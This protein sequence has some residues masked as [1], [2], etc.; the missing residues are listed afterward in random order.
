V[1]DRLLAE[2]RLAISSI[3][4]TSA[5][6]MNGALLAEGL[7][8]GAAGARAALARFWRGVG[9]RGRVGPFQPTLYDRLRDDGNIDTAPGWLA[10]EAAMRVSSPYVFNPWGYNPLKALLE[11]VLDVARLRAAPVQLFVAATNVRSGKLRLFNREEVSVEVLLASSCLPFLFQAIDID[12][13][14]YWDGGYMGN[15]TIYPLIHRCA[16]SDIVIVQVNPIARS[17]V[18]RHGA[19][20]IDR[21]NE[22][23]FNATMMRELR[24][25]GL[26][27]RLLAEGRL[28]PACGLRTIRVHLIEAD[29]AMCALNLSSKFNTDPAF[30]ERLRDLGA[31][32]A[33]RWLAANGDAIGVRSTVD[34]AAFFKDEASGPG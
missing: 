30:L 2:P 8:A 1:L 21:M 13:E 24:G 19:Q 5:G 31:A 28:D 3:S 17:E 34:F 4:G 16:T 18:P 11:E 29:P 20:I 26:V 14:S 23:S 22:I 7:T 12:G 25:V 15:P 6:A 33:G 32:A 10:L 27:N 9:A